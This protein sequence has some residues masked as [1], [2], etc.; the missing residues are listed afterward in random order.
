MPEF[1]QYKTHGR[2]HAYSDI[3]FTLKEV[4]TFNAA[5]SI[6]VYVTRKLSY[7]RTYLPLLGSVYL[8][9]NKGKETPALV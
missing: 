4:V 8:R 7:T 9:R 2:Y 3:T 6:L 1:T 5:V